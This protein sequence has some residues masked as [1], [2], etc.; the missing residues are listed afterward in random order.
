MNRRELLQVAGVFAT[1]AVTTQ[2]VAQTKIHDHQHHTGNP[3]F[4]LI[5][6][7]SHA[8]VAGQACFQHC[9]ESLGKGEKD[10][11]A[12]ASN[13]QQMMASL[14][15]LQKL[16]SYNSPHLKKMARV[17]HDICVDCEKECRKHEKKHAQ[18]KITADA[19]A[20]ASKEAGKIAI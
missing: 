2:A 4:T 19:C 10:M 15:A 8:Q 18:C 9:L 1:A 14:D 17:A 20:A 6:A 13:V 11:A 3:Y 5:A 7:V 16:A 12:C